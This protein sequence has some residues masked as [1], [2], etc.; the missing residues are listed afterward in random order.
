AS[1]QPRHLASFPTRRSSDLPWFRGFAREGVRRPGAGRLT[2]SPLAGPAP[3]Y[4]AGGAGP[5]NLKGRTWTGLSA[6]FAEV[7]TPSRRTVRSEEHTSELQSR[8]NLV[9][10][11]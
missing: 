3:F 2:F 4:P 10:R 7:K 6:V 11:L 8:E 1:C 9:C 5:F